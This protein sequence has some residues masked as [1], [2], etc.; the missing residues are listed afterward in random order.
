MIGN[1][2]QATPRAAAKIKNAPR[3]VAA[4]ARR[5]KGDLVFGEVAILSQSSGYGLAQHMIVLVCVLIEF[6]SVIPLAGPDGAADDE[7]PLA[8]ELE[9]GTA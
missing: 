6:G 1:E 2:R 5:P 3:L 7:L 4:Q 9:V 8:V